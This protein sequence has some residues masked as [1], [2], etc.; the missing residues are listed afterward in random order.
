MTFQ[1]FNMPTAI[2]KLLKLIKYYIIS[3]AVLSCVLFYLK[4]D[5]VWCISYGV[6]TTS[7]THDEV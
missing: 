4:V 5:I 6:H 3:Y 2:G 7:Q 1:D